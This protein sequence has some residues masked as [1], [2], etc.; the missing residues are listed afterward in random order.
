MLFCIC[1]WKSHKKVGWVALC[2][3]CETKCHNLVMVTCSNRIKMSQFN[4]ITMHSL[5]RKSHSWVKCCNCKIKGHTWVI[6]PDEKVA[7]DGY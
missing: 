4:N 5:K 2:N 3:N 7:I 1:V 6:L